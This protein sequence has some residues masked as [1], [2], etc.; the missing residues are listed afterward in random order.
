MTKKVYEQF[1][2]SLQ[3]KP[4]NAIEITLDDEVMKSLNIYADLRKL[5]PAALVEE[6]VTWHLKA[7]GMV[8]QLKE[9]SSSLIKQ[10]NDYVR[11]KKY[12]KN[13]HIKA[14]GE[15]FI[16]E[17][18][19]CMTFEQKCNVLKKSEQELNAYL[20]EHKVQYWETRAVLGAMKRYINL[21]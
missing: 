4:E 15:N 14:C 11:I 13:Q 2:K 3:N 16:A 5:T 9:D 8:Y 12:Y 17:I 19:T 6:I 10:Y 20:R 1:A 21:T 18:S 7:A